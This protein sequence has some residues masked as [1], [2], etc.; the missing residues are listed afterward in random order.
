M[1]LK[2]FF[3]GGKLE[4]AAEARSDQTELAKA[5]ANPDTRY[6][7]FWQARCMVE[8]DAIVLLKQESLGGDW[9]LNDSI[10]LGH[11]RN[12]HVFAIE[13]PDVLHPDGPDEKA[14]DNFRALMGSFSEEDAAL[15]AYG[16]GMVEWQTR[17]RYCGICGSG[18]N[19]V[20]GGFIMECSRAGCG[21]RS[22][23]RL[24]PA[25]IVLTVHED[26]CLL[27]RQ[28]SWPEGRYSTI[29]GF[30]EPGE[31]LEDAIAREVLEET[32]VR[33]ANSRYLGS[34]PWP[35]PNAIMLGFHADAA[36]TDIRLNDGELADANWFTREDLAA[37]RVALPPV[38]SI[39][40]QLI[41]HWFNHW[42]G[43]SLS[44][45]ELSTDFQRRPDD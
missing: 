27:G 39:A 15:L 11:I 24:D 35:F 21:A 28:V 18:N 12:Q 22:F 10:Y 43:P 44:S 42:D 33:V 34:Q 6:I 2:T 1:T 40:F 8:H 26:R 36:S 25:I 14:F 9:Q 29:A 37:G 32:N 5:W 3:S 20:S 16:K 19:A 13:L 23:P 45:L 17:H 4:R 31:S 7:A 38:Q 41:E 30:V